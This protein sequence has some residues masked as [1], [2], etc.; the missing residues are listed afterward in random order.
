[1]K[2]NSKEKSKASGVM[3]VYYVK[4]RGKRKRKTFPVFQP[5]S[6][7]VPGPIGNEDDHA[8]RKQ[9]I[10]NNMRLLMVLGGLSLISS[11]K[12]GWILYMIS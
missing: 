2:K 3:K 4:E 7:T 6:I 10:V 8:E 9:E 12:L 11:P 5:V 1:M